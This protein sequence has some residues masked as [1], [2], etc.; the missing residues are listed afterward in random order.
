MNRYLGEH[1]REP[2]PFVWTADPIVSSR[3]L[4]VGIKCW[5][6][7]TLMFAFKGPDANI[8]FRCSG[9][10]SA[11]RCARPETEPEDAG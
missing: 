10:G 1:N 5:R 3:S 2:K 7:T 8:C 6:Q 4:I 11:R 9:R